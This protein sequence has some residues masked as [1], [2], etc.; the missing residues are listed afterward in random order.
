MKLSAARNQL[1][2]IQCLTINKGANMKNRFIGE[3]NWTLSAIRKAYTGRGLRHALFWA[4]YATPDNLTN[5]YLRGESAE[6]ILAA[7]IACDTVGA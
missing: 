3:F 6:Y 1:L 5:M 4:G 7:C 2:K